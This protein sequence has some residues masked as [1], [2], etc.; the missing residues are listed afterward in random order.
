MNF[1]ATDAVP[2]A[3]SNAIAGGGTVVSGSRGGV[4][5]WLGVDGGCSKCDADT[6]EDDAGVTL[7]R[8]ELGVELEGPV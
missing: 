5:V 3:A 2:D 6:S 8:D 1:L 7:P 4:G